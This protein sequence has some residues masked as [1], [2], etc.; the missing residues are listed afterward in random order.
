[1]NDAS[2]LLTINIRGTRFEVSREQLKL[3]G[4][5]KL[6]ALNRDSAS[7]RAERNEHYFDANPSFFHCL[8]DSC[9]K[10][11][12]LHLPTAMCIEHAKQQMSFWSLSDASLAPCCYDRYDIDIL[13]SATCVI[14]HYSFASACT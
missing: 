11:C 3:I 10:P 2:E 4:S 8:L 12:N 9:H 1:M 7:Y 13:V 5:A 14:K 6:C